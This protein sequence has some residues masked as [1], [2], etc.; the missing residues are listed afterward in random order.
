MVPT[1]GRTNWTKQLDEVWKP[2]IYRLIDIYIY[3]V[4][5]PEKLTCSVILLTLP[6]YM[7]VNIFIYSVC[8]FF[9]AILGNCSWSVGSCWP[10][11]SG[12]EFMLLLR[13]P[14]SSMV[15]S[16]KLQN[17]CKTMANKPWCLQWN[18]VKSPKDRTVL[19]QKSGKFTKPLVILV[20][21][22]H[23]SIFLGGCWVAIGRFLDFQDPIMTSSQEIFAEA[24]K[25][26]IFD[27]EL[28]NDPLAPTGNSLDKVLIYIYIHISWIHS[29]L[30]PRIFFIWRD[31]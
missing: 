7:D 14:W 29:F 28:V 24:K 25:R 12:Q 18:H 17:L 27:P 15:K 21:S 9:P 2:E 10:S 30:F 4:L 8:K 3:M 6:R 22:C 11:A 1:S 13:V 19:H 20:F 23:F 16:V 31:E 5:P 26:E